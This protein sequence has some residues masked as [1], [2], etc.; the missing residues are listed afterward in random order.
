MSE[1]VSNKSNLWRALTD[2][3]AV[4]IV[5]APTLNIPAPLIQLFLTDYIDIFGEALDESQS[6]IREVTVTAPPSD[7]IRSPRHQMFSDLPTPA[8]NQTGFAQVMSGFQPL[9]PPPQ[10]NGRSTY[11]PHPQQ[12]ANSNSL[13][14]GSYSHQ[15]NNSG[16]SFGSLDGMSQQA[17]GNKKNRRESSMM[18]MNVGLVNQRQPSR[19]NMRDTSGSRGPDKARDREAPPER[20][21]APVPL[22]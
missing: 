13:Q 3:A 14:P 1:M 15:P 21:P 7:S 12:Y 17:G 11:S 20:Q 16:D 18:G 4:A 19:Q 10:S 8:Y 9:A 6:P 5:F 2:V 22:Y